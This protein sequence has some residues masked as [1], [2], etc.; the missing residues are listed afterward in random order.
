MTCNVGGVERPIRMGIAVISHLGIFV[1]H[2]DV[3]RGSGC[4]L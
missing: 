4:A 1:T 2:G 3:G